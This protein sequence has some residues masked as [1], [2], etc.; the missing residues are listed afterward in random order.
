[1]TVRDAARLM[2]VSER[3]V[4]MARELQICRPDLAAKVMA[5]EL[6]VLAALRIAKPEKYSKKRE[7]LDALKNA[8]V[9]ASAAERMS[10]LAWIEQAD[11]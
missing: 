4:Y 9:R 6:S 3:M 7:P 11:G 2:N 1:M 5:G 8:W 10:F